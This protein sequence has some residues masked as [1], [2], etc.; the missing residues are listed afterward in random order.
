MS[1]S[2]K[3]KWR[4][5][6]NIAL[7]YL[8]EN[9]Y[10]II[11]RNYKIKIDNIEVGEVDAI[12]EDS[13]GCKYA[14]EIKAG[15]IDV[16]GIRQAYVNAELLKMKPLIIAK[17]YADESAEK[18]AEQLGVKIILLSDVYLVESEELETVVYSAINRILQDVLDTLINNQ[19]IT[20]E[21]LDFIE[22]LAYSKTIKDL[23]EKCN[24][25]LNEVVW[26][27]K[28]LENKG[29]LKSRGRGFQEL[30]LQAQLVFLREK[31]RRVLY[32]IQYSQ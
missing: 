29:V 12:V 28:R 27:I 4:S 9:G 32:R 22:K 14:V 23:A 16:N 21:E 20:P 26:K 7:Q 18:L 13:E 15:N 17:G 24:L 10:K 3:R 8:E 6:E 5:S 30:R 31:I 19:S 25:G 1:I 11:E 2:P